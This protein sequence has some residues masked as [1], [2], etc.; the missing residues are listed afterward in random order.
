MPRSAPRPFLF[1]VLAVTACGPALQPLPPMAPLPEL[2]PLP[3]APAPGG[4]RVA[5]NPRETYPALES[6]R[7]RGLIVPVK[8]VT[9]AQIPDTYDERRDGLRVHNAQDIL[10]KRGTPVLAADDGTILHVGKNTLGGNV[11]WATDRSKQLAF[12]YAHLER[13]AKGLKDGQQISRGDVI[14]YV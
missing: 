5:V 10:A 8:G 12:Y 6:L 11:I 3:P 7:A 4:E 13:Y 1:L 9:A 2:A 14:G